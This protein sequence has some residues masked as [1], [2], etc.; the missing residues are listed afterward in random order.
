MQI[1]RIVLEKV[2]A[3]QHCKPP[4]ME[5]ENLF[6]QLIFEFNFLL[7]D[8][9]DHTIIRSYDHK[10]EYFVLVVRKLRL[11][12]RNLAIIVSQYI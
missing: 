4:N 9:R 5:F 6:V 8:F 2:E 3:T 7:F 11:L 1:L 12:K 10:F